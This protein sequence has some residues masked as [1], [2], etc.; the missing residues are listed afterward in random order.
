[1]GSAYI[2]H[3]DFPGQSGEIPDTESVIKFYKSRGWVVSDPPREPDLK[4]TNS[5]EPRL[6]V[7]HPDLDGPGGEIPNTSSVIKLYQELGWVLSERPVEETDLDGAET[8]QDQT[9][10]PKSIKKTAPSGD[11]KNQGD[12]S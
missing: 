1:M 9:K 11:K 5:D 10:P 8:A 4:L 2:T 3:P 7:T 12:E 6:W